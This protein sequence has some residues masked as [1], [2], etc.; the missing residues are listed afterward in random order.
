[1]LGVQD[2]ALG[3]THGEGG[4]RCP[5]GWHLGGEGNQHGV[6][7]VG[8]GVRQRHVHAVGTGWRRSR[9]VGVHLAALRRQRHRQVDRVV[10]AV[11][12]HHIGVRPGREVGEPFPGGRGCAVKD[13]GRQLLE[14]VNGEF[15]EHGV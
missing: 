6:G 9:E 11:D 4:Q 15:V 2:A 14:V 8:V 5:V 13:E 1:M 3:G 12:P 10:V 7:E